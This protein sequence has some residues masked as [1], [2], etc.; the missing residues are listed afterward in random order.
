[1]PNTNNA[2]AKLAEISDANKVR[3]ICSNAASGRYSAMFLAESN[4]PIITSGMAAVA[5]LIAE[6]SARDMAD[7]GTVG[8]AAY[9]LASLAPLVEEIA[10]GG[11]Q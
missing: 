2:Q 8:D 4:L 9:V 6:S 5:L 10:S 1:M 11:A 3:S 7:S